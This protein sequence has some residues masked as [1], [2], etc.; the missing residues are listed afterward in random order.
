M[1]RLEAEHFMPRKNEV[2]AQIDVATSGECTG[3][4]K[5]VFLSKTD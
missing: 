1:F 2:Q 3:V 4:A 5:A